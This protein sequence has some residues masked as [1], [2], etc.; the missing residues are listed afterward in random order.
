MEKRNR[1]KGKPGCSESAEEETVAQSPWKAVALVA[2]V[3]LGFLCGLW[4]AVAPEPG[5]VF[6]AQSES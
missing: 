1:A 6:P 5:A 3:V 2:A 4:F